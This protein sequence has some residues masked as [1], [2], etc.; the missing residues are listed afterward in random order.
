VT[1]QA[2]PPAVQPITSTHHRLVARC[3]RRLQTAP[4][5]AAKTVTSGTLA[6]F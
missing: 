4:R 6:L 3:L 1:L 2:N 5:R